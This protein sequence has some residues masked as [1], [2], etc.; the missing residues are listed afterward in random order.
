MTFKDTLQ[1]DL[2]I[3]LNEDEFA[4][5]HTIDGVEIV[6]VIDKDVLETGKSNYGIQNTQLQQVPGIYSSIV[7]VFAK[8][9]DFPDRPVVDQLII[10]DGERY[11]VGSCGSNDGM[12][13]IV[14]E[15]Y[16]A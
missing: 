16:K 14:L 2:D 4:E 3:F 5:T 6:C 7:V 1:N 15:A 12:L 10:L 11:T 8:D 9:S 13:E